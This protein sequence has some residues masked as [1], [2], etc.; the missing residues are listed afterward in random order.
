M[1]REMRRGVAALGSAAGF[2]AMLVVAPPALAD[3]NAISFPMV[4]SAGVAAC[5]PNAS[6]QVTISSLGAVE[7]MRV[8]VSGLPANSDFDFFVIQVPK[9][10]FGIAWYQGD[11]E[12]DAQGHG[13]GT[14]LGRFSIETFAV[15][16]GGAPAPVVHSGPFPDASLN[17]SFNPIH[18][19][20]LGLWF[21]SPADATGAGCAATVT[22]FNGDHTA[23]IQVLNT[24]NFAD[25]QGPLRQ[26]VGG[27]TAAGLVISPASGRY[28]S[29]Q[30]FDLDILVFAPGKTV[31]GGQATVD[32]IDVTAAL[33]HCIV[34]GTLVS[35]GFTLKCPGLHG[36]LLAPGPHTVGVSLDLSGGVTVSDTVIWN[37]D[38][39]T[40]P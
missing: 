40:G 5:L 32:G 38:A 35:G 21:N 30:N 34:P 13:E 17:P 3:A 25:D 7:L 22:P 6:G 27:P 14:F 20:H 4:H 18:M 26:V 24:S 36:G 16:P 15:A 28:A 31:V 1:T 11:I 29:N 23:G 9:A 2:M 12:T 33:A 39:A 37:I 19:F 8:T 10:P